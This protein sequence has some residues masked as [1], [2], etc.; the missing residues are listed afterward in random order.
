MNEALRYRVNSEL[1]N[2]YN[3][4]IIEKYGHKQNRC[5]SEITKLMK[6]QLAINGNESYQD[7]PDVMDLM[8][9]VQKKFKHTS[10]SKAKTDNTLEER[11]ER[12]LEEKFDIMKKEILV[13]I[14]N[15]SKR[16]SSK[17]HG[18]AEFKKQSN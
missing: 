2:E 12:K 15:Q 17:K 9:T 3:E 13:Q 14:T 7:D 6:L 5:G 16:E 11:L 8:D 10:P 1:K 18:L 4:F